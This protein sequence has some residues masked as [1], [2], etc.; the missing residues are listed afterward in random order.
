MAEGSQMVKQDSDQGLS[1]TTITICVAV[2]MTW[3]LWGV[4]CAMYEAAHPV[5][6]V[7]EGSLDLRP[8]IGGRTNAPIF[9]VMGV[10]TFVTKS[11][12]LLPKFPEVIGFLF[13]E[14]LWFIVVA[15]GILAG[16]VVFGIFLKRME[17][18]LE[19]AK[20]KKRRRKP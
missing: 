7:E 18:A 3:L 16:V 19:G 15:A 10:I 12:S 17:L 8:H 9:A 1:I 20:K 4:S 2:V 5:V 11:F 6:D 13:R 14:R